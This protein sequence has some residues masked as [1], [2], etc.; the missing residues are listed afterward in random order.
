MSCQNNL[1]RHRVLIMTDDYTTF[2]VVVPV[3]DVSAQTMAQ[4]FWMY[5]V[6]PYGYPIK[7]LTDQG[8]AF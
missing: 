4:A 2:V 8:T 1:W 7:V 6:R 5:F 3:K